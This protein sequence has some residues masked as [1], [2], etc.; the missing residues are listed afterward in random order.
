MYCVFHT[1]QGKNTLKWLRPGSCLQTRR[2]G[3][4]IHNNYLDRLV[5]FVL[6]KPRSLGPAGGERIKFLPILIMCYLGIILIHLLFRERERGGSPAWEWNVGRKPPVHPQQKDV[7]ANPKQGE[8]FLDASALTQM[9]VFSLVL[10]SSDTYHQHFG[11]VCS[12][13]ISQPNTPPPPT[14][15]IIDWSKYWGMYWWPSNNEHVRTC[16]YANTGCIFSWLEYFTSNATWIYDWVE[17]IWS[18]AS[19]TCLPRQSLP[20]SAPTFSQHKVKISWESQ[21]PTWSLQLWW[22]V[23]C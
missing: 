6:S 17:V 16:H 15:S 22:W 23:T 5:H 19:S 13:G 2:G 3:T 4:V 10:F 1:M 18:L 20:L 11:Q 14:H 9:C 12:D 8:L 7:A 21:C